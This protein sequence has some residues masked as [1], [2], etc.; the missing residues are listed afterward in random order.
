MALEVALEQLCSNLRRFQDE[1][2][3]LEY[4]FEHDTPEEGGV[5]LVSDLNDRVTDLRGFLI[6]AMSSAEEALEAEQSA[7]EPNQM[8]RALVYSQQHF[9]RLQKLFYGDLLTYESAKELLDFGRRAGGRWP[10]WVHSVLLGLDVCRPWLEAS[11]ES[12][13][14][15][16]Q[17]I[18]ERATTGPVSVHATNI[19]QQ[20]TTARAA[21]GLVSELG[22]T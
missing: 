18:A 21:S 15:A 4:T 9:L 12:Y 1:L 8:R 3:G 6:E 13:C 20:I 19:G 10:G 17:E 22:A 16:W 11:A 5:R 7:Q 14:Q 2:S